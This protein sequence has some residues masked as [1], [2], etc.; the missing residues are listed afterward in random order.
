MTGSPA[1]SS[2]AASP[3]PPPKRVL[4][5]TSV[6]MVAAP[7]AVA[8]DAVSDVDFVLPA[9]YVEGEKADKES[10]HSMTEDE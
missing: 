2:P 6:G 8:A 7:V 3:V 1:T 5:A 10:L 4:V 9:G